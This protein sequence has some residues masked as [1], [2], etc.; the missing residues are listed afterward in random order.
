MGEL[1]ARV[2]A[3]LRR[4]APAT[5][6]AMI[7]TDAFTI[8]L[9]AKRVT[10]ADG[11]VRLTPT[12]WHLVEVLVRNSGKLVTQG[13][14]L[15]EVWG[16]EYGT[17]TNYLRVY[18]AHIRRKLE[19][20]P[21][22]PAFF[23]TE[24]G[25][26]YRFED[27][28]RTLTYAIQDWGGSLDFAHRKYTCETAPAP[29]LAW[30][31]DCCAQT[32]RHHP[33]GCRSARPRRVW[34]WFVESE[35][36]DDPDIRACGRERGGGFSNAA[37]TTCLKQQG[38]TLPSGFGGG[39]RRGGLGGSGGSGG[40]GGPR[41]GSGGR[42]RGFFGG[43][44]GGAGG[45]LG[46]L[47]AKQQ[48]RVHRVQLEAARRR[49]VRRRRR[50]RR[51]RQRD[52]TQGVLVVPERQRRESTEGRDAGNRRLRSRTVCEPTRER[53]Q[54]SPLRCREREVRAVATVVR[55]RGDSHD[56][57]RRLSSPSTDW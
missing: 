12:E 6:E 57:G 56:R 21:A 48:R 53:P 14:M 7:V 15:R 2:R 51:W 55:R 29:R 20:D 43:G 25:M 49:S 1:L 24:P 54:R 8:D 19:P 40:F 35:H 32:L 42:G 3:A 9:A 10:N 30:S 45:L 13:A 26:G 28:R 38:V 22:N 39:G 16:P 44:S 5:E 41:G 11:E 4:G 27:P 52:A 31:D 33:C 46:N 50:V 34:R 36:R 17:E 47:T 37:F 23:I 18:M